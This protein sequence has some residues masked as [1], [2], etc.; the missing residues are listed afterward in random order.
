MNLLNLSIYSSFSFTKLYISKKCREV[1]QMVEHQILILAV[2]GSSPAFPAI[3]FIMSKILIIKQ[4][5]IIM[6][7]KQTNTNCN[8]FFRDNK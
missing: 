7:T 8:F 1:A 5:R 2:V 6:N 3:I 4:R